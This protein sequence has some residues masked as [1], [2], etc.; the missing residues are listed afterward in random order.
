MGLPGSVI[1][2]GLGCCRFSVCLPRQGHCLFHSQAIEPYPPGNV[3]DDLVRSLNMNVSYTSCEEREG[4][5]QVRPLCLMRQEVSVFGLVRSCSRSWGCSFCRVVFG[6]SSPPHS[7]GRPHSQALGLVGRHLFGNFTRTQRLVESRS[8]PS[9]PSY[10]AWNHSLPDEPHQPP[11]PPLGLFKLLVVQNPW[12]RNS[13]MANLQ[14][15]MQEGT[16]IWM[17]HTSGRASPPILLDSTC[18]WTL[19]QA[20]APPAWQ[21]H[22]PQKAILVCFFAGWGG[23]KRDL[24]MWSGPPPRPQIRAWAWWHGQSLNEKCSVCERDSS[25]RRV[26]GAVLRAALS[27][28][29][30]HVA[31]AAANDAVARLLREHPE[32]LNDPVGAF[33]VGLS[34]QDTLR[35]TFRGDWRGFPCGD[36]KMS[37]QQ[38]FPIFLGF[39]VMR[40]SVSFGSPPKCIENVEWQID[41][42]CLFRDITFCHLP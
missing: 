20:S 1:V 24:W 12:N 16:H 41:R 2:S 36:S 14:R 35:A 17:L 27:P 26:R 6:R 32:T 34:C 31:T 18:S 28:D 21:S 22:C 15:I 33:V 42:D 25:L 29:K 40:P 23:S 5:T 7:F 19:P 37:I 30:R 39:S 13:P 11:P 9:L 38:C 3:G 8:T 4:E 10:S